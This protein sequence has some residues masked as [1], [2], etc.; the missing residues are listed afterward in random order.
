MV[1]GSFLDVF[2][3]AD[4]SRAITLVFK[5]VRLSRRCLMGYV[6][7]A[8]EG[9]VTKIASRVWGKVSAVEVGAV[10]FEEETFF[11]QIE[12]GDFTFAFSHYIKFLWVLA[13]FKWV[14]CISF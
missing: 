13:Q 9:E 3:E 6:R 12:S 14:I 8:N 10:L 2:D 5:V 1:S 7:D 11:K 4:D